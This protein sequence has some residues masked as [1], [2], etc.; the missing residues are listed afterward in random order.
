MSKYAA[1]VQRKAYLFHR[2]FDQS[3]TQRQLFAESIV[4]IVS[5]ALQGYNCTVFA[6]GQTGTGK[7]FTLEGD[8]GNPSR[9]GIIPR[10]IHHLF[11]Q[12]DVAPPGVRCF[13]GW[14]GGLCCPLPLLHV[15]TMPVCFSIWRAARVHHHGVTSGDL[16]RGAG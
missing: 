7:T 11:Q 12:I 6:Y 3:T 4:P 2:V 9:A 16:Q 10:C 5:K 1:Y 13:P 8:M 14:W 15:L